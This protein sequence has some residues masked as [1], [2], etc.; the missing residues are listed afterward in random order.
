MKSEIKFTRSEMQIINYIT[1]GLN[2]MEIAAIR[3]SS[4]KTIEVHRQNILKK[5]KCRNMI[6]LVVKLFR[7]GIIK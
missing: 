2:S 6:E 1:E 3:G 7:E 5:S 4:L